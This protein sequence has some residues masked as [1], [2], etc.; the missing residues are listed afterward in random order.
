MEGERKE[1]GHYLCESSSHWWP[2]IGLNNLYTAAH[3]MFTTISGDAA[4]PHF[5]NE[6]IESVTLPV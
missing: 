2:W 1:R 6:E 5:A 3:R 4:L